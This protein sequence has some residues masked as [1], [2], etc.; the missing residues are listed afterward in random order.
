MKKALKRTANKCWHFIDGKKIDGA[1]LGLS[2]D[3]T[4]LSGNVNG[5]S[6]N[7]SGLS[8]DVDECG[9]S[10]EERAKGVEVTTLIGG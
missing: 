5:L 10:D 6:G 3:V 1:P 7:V 9:L 4:G 8:G 2:G